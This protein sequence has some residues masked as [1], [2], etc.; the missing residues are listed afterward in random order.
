MDWF[1]TLPSLSFDALL[2]ML[3]NEGQEIELISDEKIYR[4]V[5]KALRVSIL[6]KMTF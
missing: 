2:R 3:Q 6:F 1:I 5:Q 4:F